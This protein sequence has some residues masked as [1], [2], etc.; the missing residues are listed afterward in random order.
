MQDVK[1]A[2]Y[3]FDFYTHY[4]KKEYSLPK[5]ATPRGAPKGTKNKKTK[6]KKEN[7]KSGLLG[8]EVQ[9]R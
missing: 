3:P 9:E 4:R 8:F 1:R 6:E 5:Y 7:E 2:S